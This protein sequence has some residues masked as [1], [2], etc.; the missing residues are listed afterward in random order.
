[1]H[2][3]INKLCTIVYIY[4]NT[5]ILKKNIGTQAASFLFV[6]GMV[7]LYFY[8]KLPVPEYGK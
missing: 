6:V 8:Y 3:L 2:S 4:L 5:V 1:M 7:I